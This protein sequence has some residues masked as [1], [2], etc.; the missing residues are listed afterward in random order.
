[1]LVV[2]NG[3][4][5]DSVELIKQAFPW[6]RVIEHADN[7]GFP[8][9]VNAGIRE[10]RGEFIA[11]LNNDTRA[12]PDWLERLVGAMKRWPDASFAACKMLRYEPPHCIDSAGDRFSLL[13]GAGSNLGAGQPREA[14]S[15]FAWT[16]G[17]CAGAALYRRAL[18][19]DIGLFD[20]DFFLVFEDVDFDLRA[21]VAGHRCLY[22]PDAVVYHKRGASTDSASL[23]VR[24]RIW[25]NAVWVAGKN[26]PPLLLS[27]WLVAFTLRLA[28][29]AVLSGL[30]GAW[31]RLRP[32]ATG[33]A[34]T[35]NPS[36]SRRRSR[37]DALR[38]YYGPALKQALSSLPSKRREIRHLRRRGS[39]SLLPSLLRPTRP[40]SDDRP[41]L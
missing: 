29:R 27:G 18:F 22:V 39:L 31:Q 26:L 9:A 38:H 20:E 14:H 25:R 12:E 15:E 10:S 7:R 1:V 21:Q 28:R 40:I 32:T 2:D 33:S 3:S 37:L 11:L 19:D 35:N 36:A 5:D 24:S 16:F 13:A 30:A 23:E 6:V 34:T 8:A 41:A 17:A 4:S